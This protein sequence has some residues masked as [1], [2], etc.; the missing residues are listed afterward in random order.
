VQKSTLE[1]DIM[2]LNQVE[3]DVVEPFELDIGPLANLK[4]A[5][6]V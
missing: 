2:S 1:V 3:R 4:D 6:P 5:L